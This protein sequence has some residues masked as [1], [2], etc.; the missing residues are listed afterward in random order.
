MTAAR[1]SVFTPSHDPRFLNDAYASLAGQTYRDWEWIVLLNGGAEWEHPGDPRVQL[2]RAYGLK[3][4]GA[5]KRRACELASGE[6]LV[7]LDHDDVLAPSALEEVVAAFDEHPA[8]GVVYSDFAQITAH[9]QRD[10]T[11]FNLENGWE[12][13]EDRVAD[14]EVLACAAMEPTPHNVSYVW[15]AP[16]HVRAFRGSIYE[17]AG[18]Y[19]AGRDVL[20]DQDLLARMYRLAPFHRVP[21]CLYLQRMHHAN[22]QTG[23]ATNA[24]I[25]IETVDLYERDV[26][27]CA[28]AWARREGL[29]AIDLGAAH[30][31]PV[32][33][34]G[35]DQYAGEGVDIVADV[36]VEGI[37][38]ATSSVGVL[39]AVDFLE[40]VPDKIGLLNEMYRVLAP[41]GMLLSLTPSTDGRGAFQDP[42]HV[43]F[44]NEN[45]F[46]YWTEREYAA[47][48][49]Q[50]ECRFQVSR[51]RTMFP[52][53]WHELH[54]VPYVQANLIAI[55][56]GMARNGG[57]VR[58]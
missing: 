6:L 16:N 19:D 18:G 7:E 32:G 25:Q 21:R 12:Y 29:R 28:L 9:G 23:S 46:W 26:Q 36:A 44:Y 8:V 31:K 27:E 48:V 4:V 30:R 55:K 11:K 40:H 39:R 56:D 2:H 51:L 37:P 10:D 52:S 41:G 22:T 13:R 45:S 43:A 34:E 3:G 49:P 1:V 53:D 57:P 35:L 33:Y 14:L 38:L 24:R 15:F 42:T 5:V 58:I 20:D 47:F 17:R 50:I 54:Q